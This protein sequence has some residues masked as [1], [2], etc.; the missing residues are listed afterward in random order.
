MMCP[1]VDIVSII[2]VV[3]PC[4]SAFRSFYRIRV[5]PAVG[6]INFVRSTTKL[7]IDVTGHISP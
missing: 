5:M 2:Y 3:D 4:C 7:E 1:V 6:R